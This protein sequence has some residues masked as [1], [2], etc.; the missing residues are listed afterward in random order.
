LDA[1]DWLD[2]EV[3][4]LILQRFRSDPTL[5]AVFGQAVIHENGSKRIEAFRG[6]RSEV[7]CLTYRGVQAPRAYKTELLKSIGGWSTN[8]IFEG[9]FF[10][11]RLTL[12]RI[13]RVSKVSFIR[14]P[15]YHV[16]VRS[17]SLSRRVPHRTAIAKFLILSGEANRTRLEL[18]ASLTRFGLTVAEAPCRGPGTCLEH[19]YSGS[20]AGGAAEVCIAILDRKRCGE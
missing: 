9:R 7:E 17:D 14:R 15:L 18:E 11:D 6:V 4:E 5:G 19:C 20:R 1:D 8:D 2:P 13:F 3:L 10:E 12:A 16:H